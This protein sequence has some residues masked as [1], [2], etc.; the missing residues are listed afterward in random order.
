MLN[1]IVFQVV[2]AGPAVVIKRL[3]C[4]WVTESAN[5]HK[6][7]NI[8][9]SCGFTPTRCL[10]SFIPLFGVRKVKKL[11]GL[12]FD[13][14]MELERNTT[15]NKFRGDCDGDNPETT[16]WLSTS[17]ITRLDIFSHK[18]TYRRR[19]IPLAISCRPDTKNNHDFISFAPFLQYSNSV[20]NR[21]WRLAS[22][23]KTSQ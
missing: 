18:F 9:I 1:R 13:W 6:N 7:D 11:R 4:M 12:G 8:S 14:L 10:K 23:D 5:Y 22:A 19:V 3:A 17:L 21:V 2:A 20:W 16:A 15:V